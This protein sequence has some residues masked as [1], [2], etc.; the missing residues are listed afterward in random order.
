MDHGRL[1]CNFGFF[2]RN[3]YHSYQQHKGLVTTSTFHVMMMV[4]MLAPLARML[5]M[6]LIVLMSIV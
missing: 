2:D 1:V 4:M 6:L 3:E 5:S